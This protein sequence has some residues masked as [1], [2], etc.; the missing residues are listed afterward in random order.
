MLEGSNLLPEGWL[1]LLVKQKQ[2]AITDMQAGAI[3]HKNQLETSCQSGDS[4]LVL[5]FREPASETRA[6]AS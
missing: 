1:E 5:H 4:R 2:K 6:G 3:F